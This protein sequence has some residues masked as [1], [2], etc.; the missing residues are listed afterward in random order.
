MAQWDGLADMN[1]WAMYCAGQRT[2][3]PD[4]PLHPSAKWAVLEHAAAIVKI[5][6][7]HAARFVAYCLDSG[8]VQVVTP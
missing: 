3:P 8:I 4:A 2:T 5:D 1:D 6:R 7:D